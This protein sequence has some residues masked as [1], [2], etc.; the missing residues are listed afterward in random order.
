MPHTAHTLRRFRFNRPQQIAAVLLA[1]L[2]AQCIWVIGHKLEL[3]P[4]QKLALIEVQA[5]HPPRTAYIHFDDQLHDGILAR[6]L[7]EFPLAVEALL[8]G[9]A[10]SAFTPRTP[11][12]IAAAHWLTCLPFT[13]AAL[14]LG[15][16]LW[17]VTRRL[18]GNTGGYIA[19]AFYCFAPPVIAAATTP[20]SD[21]WA[22]LGL[23]AAVY[24]A[25]G[26]AHAMQGP[27]RKWRPRI[28]LLIIILGVLAAAH[29]AAWILALVFLIG[30]MLY[31]I[32]GKRAYLPALVAVWIID[33]LLILFALWE[34]HPQAFLW[35]LRGGALGPSLQ[36]V[37]HLFGAPGN[38]AI[39]AATA[40]ALICYAA[41]RRIRYFGNSTPLIVA[42]VI[43][44]HTTPDIFSQTSLWALPFVLTFIG[45]VFADVLDTRGR[46]AFFGLTVALVIAQIV[47]C[48]ASL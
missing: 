22:A 3:Q 10:P 23:F 18:Y 11:P 4:G 37:Q 19:L 24:T 45:G 8:T 36:P 27:R 25:I 40:I 15:G 41:S 39:T 47:L 12:E 38:A 9:H 5:K 20:N 33:S 1:L 30:F 17:W 13:L 14:I 7:V 21:I 29:I 32:E 26:V 35:A 42:V 34:F 46:R 28:V 48:V 43:L 2:L 6:R 31:V 44:A 16:C